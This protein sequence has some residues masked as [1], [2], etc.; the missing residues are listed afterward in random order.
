MSPNIVKRFQAWWHSFSEDH[1]PFGIAE[2]LFTLFGLS[3]TLLLVVTFGV[4]GN[5]TDAILSIIFFF[6]TIFGLLI[7]NSYK[8]LIKKINTISD[9]LD[10]DSIQGKFSII[11][12]DIETI[13][14]KLDYI[15]K[16]EGNIEYIHHKVDLQCNFHDISLMIKE[17]YEKPAFKENPHTARKTLNG[18]NKKLD[19]QNI[20][21]QMAEHVIKSIRTRCQSSFSAVSSSPIVELFDPEI[22]LYFVDQALEINIKNNDLNKFP[23]GFP[24]QRYFIYNTKTIQEYNE[25]LEAYSYI[26]ANAG[27]YF[28]LIN[29]D[30]LRFRVNDILEKISSDDRKILDGRGFLKPESNLPDFVFLDNNCVYLRSHEGKLDY[31]IKSEDCRFYV[32][33]IN[34]FEKAKDY[35]FV[36]EKKVAPKIRIISRDYNKSSLQKIA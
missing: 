4:S 20:G 17:I 35:P 12:S 6:I 28:Y 32:A 3:I 1:L 14:Q 16:I 27:I 19:R 31:S 30:Q 33:Q 18:L 15:D 5:F 22:V 11:Q 21:F 24:A 9:P 8:R 10:S 23:N 2:L 25:E 36:C 7:D 26:H 29:E 34:F 13:K